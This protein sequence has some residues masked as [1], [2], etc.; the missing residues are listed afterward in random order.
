MG[1]RLTKE[2]LSDLLNTSEKSDHSPYMDLVSHK[3]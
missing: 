3:V 2:L 1:E